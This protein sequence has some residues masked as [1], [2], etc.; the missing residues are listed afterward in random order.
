MAK[1]ASTTKAT[2]ATKA[3]S[4]EKTHTPYAGEYYWT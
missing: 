4:A 2:K 3:S 1:A